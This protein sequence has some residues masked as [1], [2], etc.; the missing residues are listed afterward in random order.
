[1]RVCVCVCVCV[2][3]CVCVCVCVKRGCWLACECECFLIENTWLSTTYEITMTLVPK[4]VVA[5]C[6]TWI[7][8]EQHRCVWPTTGS[9]ASGG[10]FFIHTCV[11]GKGWTSS[12]LRLS[13][14]LPF[15]LNHDYMMIIC[16]QCLHVVCFKNYMLYLQ[17]SALTLLRLYIRH[18]ICVLCSILFMSRRCRNYTKG[19]K[20]RHTEAGRLE[21]KRKLMSENQ[22][23]KKQVR[24]AKDSQREK[25]KI[26]TKLRSNQKTTK[27]KSGTQGAHEDRETGTEAQEI[28]GWTTRL[29]W[30]GKSEGTTRAKIQAKQTRG[31]G[32]VGETLWRA[33][34]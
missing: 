5:L 7:D 27:N 23:P 21:T 3:M 4:K 28:G 20:C 30:P 14:M 17:K 24:Q 15:T 2:C 12:V 32:A 6:K 11:F 19:P 8:T 33:Q 25:L 26:H 1:M 22:N 34:C 13:R 16:Y 31:W 10:I 9:W 29:T 18:V